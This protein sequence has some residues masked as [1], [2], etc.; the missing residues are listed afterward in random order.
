MASFATSFS[1]SINNSLAEIQSA[2]AGDFSS[3]GGFGG[4]FSGGGGGGFGGFE[5]FFGGGRSRRQPDFNGPRRGDDMTFRLDIDFDEA[6]LTEVDHA[7]SSAVMQAERRVAAA[8]EAD[9]YATALDELAALRKPVD[10]FFER[11][12]VMDDDLDVR[13]NRLRLLNRFVGVFANVADFGL[14]AR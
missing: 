3:G 1:S 10:L 12:M 9:D 8:L 14:M 6:L 13:A 5:D 4:G 11:V 7:L 2:A